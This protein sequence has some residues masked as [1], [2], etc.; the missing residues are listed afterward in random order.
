MIQVNEY[1]EGKVK[2]L[3][4]TNSNG[5]ATAGVIE[6]GEYEFGTSSVEIMNI[7]WGSMQVQ[8]TGEDEWKE[9]NSG[10]S[11]RVEKNK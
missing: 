3:D 4:T 1:F 9:Y 7:I 10:T 11:F 2:S 8:L 6:A 5:K